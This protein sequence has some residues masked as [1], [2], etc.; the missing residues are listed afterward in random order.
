MSDTIALPTLAPGSLAEGPE[1]VVTER[2]DAPQ[3]PPERR[4]LRVERHAAAHRE[5][6]R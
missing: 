6:G 4:L 2:M 5:G 1:V 3:K